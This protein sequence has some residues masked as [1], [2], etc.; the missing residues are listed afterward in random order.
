MRWQFSVANRESRLFCCSIS[1]LGRLR[2]WPHF[3]RRRDSIAEEVCESS[4]S[5]NH[6]INQLNINSGSAVQ[7]GPPQAGKH[8]HGKDRGQPDV[9]DRSQRAR[10]PRCAAKA[11]ATLASWK[12]QSGDSSGRKMAERS[13]RMHGRCDRGRL[14][15]LQIQQCKPFGRVNASCTVEEADAVMKRGT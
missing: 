6:S 12:L 13:V 11:L 2:L 1:E 8:H 14:A 9:L 5:K 4:K 3:S 10:S 15:A 7:H